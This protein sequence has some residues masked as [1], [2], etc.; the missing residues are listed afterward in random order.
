MPISRVLFHWVHEGML[1]MNK[2]ARRTTLLKFLTCLVRMNNLG[3]CF[4]HGGST[5]WFSHVIIHY[6][7]QLVTADDTAEP[8]AHRLADYLFIL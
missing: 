3:I 8:L 7:V 4:C 2:W 6:V 5:Q 1:L